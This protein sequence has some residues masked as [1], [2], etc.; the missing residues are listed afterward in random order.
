MLKFDLNNVK[1]IVGK[2]VN[3]GNQYL[4]PFPKC[5]KKAHQVGIFPHNPK[6]S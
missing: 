1:N 6:F 3:A 2:G 5:F 4:L